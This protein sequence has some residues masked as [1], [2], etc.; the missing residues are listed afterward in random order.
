MADQPG[1]ALDGEANATEAAKFAALFKEFLERALHAAP[2]R[3]A[4]FRRIISEHLGTDALACPVVG[5]TFQRIEHVNLQGALDH[6]VAASGR[7]WEDLA[8]RPTTSSGVNSAKKVSAKTAR[9]ARYDC[10]SSAPTYRN[11]RRASSA[12]IGARSVVARSI[13]NAPA[14]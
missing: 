11:R 6:Y 13:V 4:P 1:A 9:I 7:S 14:R 2:G 10:H 12:L 5:R 3:E 8:N